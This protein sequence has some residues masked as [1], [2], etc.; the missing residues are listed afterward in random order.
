MLFAQYLLT[1]DVQ[2]GYAKTEGYV[3]VTFKAQNSEEYQEKTA[4]AICLG[5]IEYLKERI[6]KYL[7]VLFFM[8]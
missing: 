5:I 7:M 6:N 2:I 3:P 4:E 8:I 1:N